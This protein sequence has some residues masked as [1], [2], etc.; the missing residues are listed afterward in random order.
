MPAA[1][2]VWSIFTHDTVTSLLETEF[3][4]SFVDGLNQWRQ[5][6]DLKIVLKMKI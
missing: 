1:R 6:W 2:G 4:C 5:T 3:R